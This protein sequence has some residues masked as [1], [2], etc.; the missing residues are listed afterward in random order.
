MLLGIALPTGRSSTRPG[1]ALRVANGPIRVETSALRVL[2]AT[3]HDQCYWRM[4]FTGRRPY[5]VLHVESRANLS[6]ERNDMNFSFVP[7]NS[8]IAL[9]DH[10]RAHRMAYR[11][12]AYELLGG[13]CGIC[14]STNNLRHRFRDPSHPL[15]NSYRTN[16]VTLFRRL[17]LEPELRSVVRLLCR[18]CR[19][20]KDA[21]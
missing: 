14:G 18:A 12:Q 19:L 11:D 2:L 17:C 8:K 1:N 20:T 5:A 15:K 10:Y 7:I 3:I 6:I 16:P 4:P 13:R 9:Y 21:C